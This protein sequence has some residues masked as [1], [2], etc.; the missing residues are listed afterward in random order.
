MR[1]CRPAGF[2]I[3][4]LTDPVTRPRAVC[5]ESKNARLDA[6]KRCR[7]RFRA[8]REMR[9]G[10]LIQ[11]SR[12]C[13]SMSR[14]LGT[15]TASIGARCQRCAALPVAQR[16]LDGKLARRPASQVP[17]VVNPRQQ[18]YSNMSFI[19]HFN[20][21]LLLTYILLDV[22]AILVAYFLGG[23]HSAIMLGLYGYNAILTIIAVSAVFNAEH[24]RYSL[25]S[26]II[27]AC[28][29]VPIT[30]GLSTF[31][32]PYGLPALTMPFVLC[33]W[34]FLSARKIMPNL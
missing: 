11:V 27:A 5:F 16:P 20:N 17:T 9:L 7:P 32:L 26:G 15:P 10:S 33:T 30:A 21:I 31:L 25:L 19:S 23:E 6:A 8:L 29:T 13:I 28:L 14:T 4:G 1:T 3:R 2:R 34:L 22:T 12:R 18:L 24:N